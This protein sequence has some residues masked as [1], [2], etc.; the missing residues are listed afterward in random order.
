MPF[1]LWQCRSSASTQDPVW[2]S[3]TTVMTKPRPKTMH[4]FDLNKL[5]TSPDCFSPI[6]SPTSTMASSDSTTLV[7]TDA[8]LTPATATDH[9]TVLTSPPNIIKLFTDAGGAKLAVDLGLLPPASV[10]TTRRHNVGDS[11]SASQE[12]QCCT[13]IPTSARKRLRKLSEYAGG[14]MSST[15]HAA[16]MPSKPW[17]TGGGDVGNH[18]DVTKTLALPGGKAKVRGKNAVV[19]DEVLGAV[20]VLLMMVSSKKRRRE[21]SYISSMATER[22]T[23]VDLEPEPSSPVG[24]DRADSETTSSRSRGSGGSVLL[25]PSNKQRYRSMA[26]LMAQT[27]ILKRV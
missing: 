1:G 14:H 19:D 23:S 8:A 2:T 10:D 17:S 16:P 21:F 18:R 3:T 26:E 27:P 20:S 22:S 13:G 11:S 9:V 5:P 24:R 25:R 12:P 6:A 15:A 7:P 4:L